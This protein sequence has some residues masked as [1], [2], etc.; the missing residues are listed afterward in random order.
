MKSK[1]L[2]RIASGCLLFFAFGHT[3]G[4]FT[5][6]SVNDPK[7]KEVLRE[8]SE[9]KFDM[10]GQLRSYDE[11]YTGMSL[12]LIL[13]LLVFA[14]VLYILSGQAEKQPILVKN[15]LTPL[16]ICIVGFSITSFLYFFP[17][18]A[19]TCLVASILII[20]TIYKLGY[21]MPVGKV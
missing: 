11:N 16:T 20:I 10:F 6:H 13:T 5:R 3:V 12:N 1:I 9:N 21:K 15:L 7:A 17:L 14:V 19:I 8:M 18:P 2:L 4:H